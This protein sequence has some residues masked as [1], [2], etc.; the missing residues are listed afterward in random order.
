MDLWFRGYPAATSFAVTV[1]GSAMSLTGDGTDIWN[2]SDDFVFAYKTLTGD[3][4]IVARVVSVGTGTNTWA[5]GGVMIRDSLNGG[6]DLRRYGLTSTR[7]RRQ[8]RQLPVP[9]DDQCGRAATPTRRRSWR[10]RTG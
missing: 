5:K 2:N 7:R 3:G 9:A 10:P 6:S 8:R 1:T 4:S